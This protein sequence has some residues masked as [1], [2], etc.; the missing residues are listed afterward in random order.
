MGKQSRRKSRQKKKEN[1][2][3]DST[4]RNP[5]SAV[6]RL[7]HP[8]PKTRHSALVSLQATFLHSGCQRVNLPV[9][10]AVREQIMDRDMNCASA[11]A[12]CLAQ[13]V[14]YSEGDKHKDIMA[15]WTLILIARLDQCHQAIQVDPNNAKQWYA[16]A[17]PALRAM[18]KLIEINELALEQLNTQKQTFL[19][20]MFGLL[21][22]VV[23]QAATLDDQ[24]NEWV[25]D[26]GTY[27]ARCI[28]SSIDDNYEMVD[29]L[30]GNGKIVDLWPSL[31]TSLPDLAQL[32]IAGC[33]ISLYQA[34]PC[35]WHSQILLNQVLP[36]LSRF[37]NIDVPKLETLEENYRQAKLMLESQ[38]EDNEIEQE[39]LKAIEQRREPARE[40]ARRMKQNP[41][42]E[43]PMMETQEDGQQAMEDALTAWN[44]AMMPLQLALENMANL[45]S[46]LIQEENEMAVEREESIDR[47]IYQ[48]LVT[49][50][51]AEYIVRM[52]Q[53]LCVYTQSRSN[54]NELLKDDLED[55]LSK[56][57]G[58]LANCV[59]SKVLLE[60]DFL[61][62]WTILRQYPSEKGVCSV[63]AALVQNSKSL[64]NLAV[65]DLETFQAMLN[66]AQNEEIQRDA[67]CLIS[68]ALARTSPPEVV[69]KMT[70]ELIKLMQEAAPTVR[71]EVLNT[72]MDLYGDDEFH[73]NV[74]MSL[75]TLSHF[76]QCLTTVP[77]KGLGPE[78]EEIVFNAHRFIEYKLGG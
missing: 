47:T 5:S 3:D 15:S 7:R 24:L 18:C 49:N 71:C 14:S 38:K 57:S 27:A 23:S 32:H 77:Q 9:L 69:A 22:S 64:R 35:D 43:K 46:C 42:E 1:R 20:T 4:P 52:L 78:E 12:E 58:C 40:I 6:H 73:P 50:K 21:Q 16:L 34:S 13:Y 2:K 17:A 75:N 48:S 33:I 67:L 70:K 65:N 54:E 53:A 59:L 44:N 29:I 10:Q 72:I 11:A 8:D 28:H 39:V 51:V 30:N 26:T 62:T 41:R 37:L 63:M 45:L 55:A 60:S 76:Q 25:H 61:A 31:L 56:I 66:N 36:C 19:S 68:A 74:F